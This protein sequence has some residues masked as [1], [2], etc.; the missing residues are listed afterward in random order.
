MKA[1]SE[2]S[3]LSGFIPP[4]GPL[5]VLLMGLQRYIIYVTA[6]DTSPLDQNLGARRRIPT[7][8]SS[9]VCLSPSLAAS[10]PPYISPPPVYKDA[11]RLSVLDNNSFNVQ[12]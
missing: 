8:S 2:T 7:S 3:Y 4:L 12:N 6:S 9:H 1:A 5:W 10:L 11:W